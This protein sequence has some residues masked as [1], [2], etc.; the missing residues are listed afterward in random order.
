MDI[1]TTETVT[2]SKGV[3]MNTPDITVPIRSKISDHYG[4]PR[5]QTEYPDHTRLVHHA[6]IPV[7]YLAYA[8]SQR[9]ARRI[10]Y[11]LSLRNYTWEHDNMLREQCDGED[12]R[13]VKLTCLTTQPALFTHWRPRGIKGKRATSVTMKKIG[14]RRGRAGILGKASG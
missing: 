9:G 10:L 7:C 14:G 2:R 8:V 3:V 13:E 1:P 4:P 6:Y 5:L 11:E 12:M